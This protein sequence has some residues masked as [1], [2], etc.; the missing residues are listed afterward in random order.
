[1]LGP[2]KVYRTVYPLNSLLHTKQWAIQMEG[3]MNAYLEGGWLPS[4]SAPGDRGAMTGHMQDASIAD[5]V[6]KR[7]WLP[8]EFN[9]TLAW[10]SVAKDAFTVDSRGRKGL[11]LYE[12][13][14]YI[15]LGHGIG[16]EVS[17]L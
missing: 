2:I 4:W 9:A 1:M 17:E 12:A 16:D 13:Y 6:V 3:W 11:E 5:A 14:G 15:P 8:A 10:E 7:K